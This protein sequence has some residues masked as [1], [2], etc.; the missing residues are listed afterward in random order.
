MTMHQMC[1]LP[2]GNR[3]KTDHGGGCGSS[4]PPQRAFVTSATVDLRVRNGSSDEGADDKSRGNG[5][6]GSD[7][8]CASDWALPC[9]FYPRWQF[10][11]KFSHYEVIRMLVRSVIIRLVTGSKTRRPMSRPR[12]DV[13]MAEPLRSTSGVL[14]TIWCVFSTRRHSS[15]SCH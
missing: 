11:I 5:R 10:I 12:M 8:L 1:S 3:G 15:G 2:L 7:R 4:S 6:Y 14:T 9:P 13:A